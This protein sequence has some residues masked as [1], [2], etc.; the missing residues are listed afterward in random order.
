MTSFDARRDAIQLGCDR[1]KGTQGGYFAIR[2][3]ASVRSTSDAYLL[4]T[5]PL[6]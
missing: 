1:N 5:V 6:P 3:R 4:R 2:R